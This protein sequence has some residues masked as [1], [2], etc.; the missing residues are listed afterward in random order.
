MVSWAKRGYTNDMRALTWGCLLT[1]FASGFSAC[2]ASD[3]KKVSASEQGGEASGGGS[4]DAG[5]L[6]DAGTTSAGAAGTAVIA[7]GQAGQG[8]NAAGSL[9]D[10]GGAGQLA[11]QRG[12]GEAGS[13]GAACQ[14]ALPLADNLHGHWLICGAVATN[15]RIWH[16]LLSFDA[17]SCTSTEL[18]GTFHWLTTNAGVS[19]GNTVFKGAYDPETGT[20]TLDEYEITGGNVVQGTDTFK[21]DPQT[22]TLTD[23]A[24]TCS[25]SP[26]TWTTATR[27]EPGVDVDDCP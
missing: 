6:P 7:G 11:G 13:G 15:A 16:G 23:G 14:S 9:D 18:T 22:D 25:C 21:Y 26:G 1:I 5:A 10:V 3:D 27:V 20:I 19:E 8:G 12:T 2:G 17:P 24:W 4:G